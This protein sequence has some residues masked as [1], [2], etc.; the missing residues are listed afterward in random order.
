MLWNGE[1]DHRFNSNCHWNEQRI[2]TL[3][4]SFDVTKNKLLNERVV[5]N[6][7]P[8]RELAH[9][10]Q[11]VT[12]IP[13]HPINSFHLRLIRGETRWLLVESVFT[14]WWKKTQQFVGNSIGNSVFNKS[15]HTRT[16]AIL[17]SHAA[18]L[19]AATSSDLVDEHCRSPSA[20]VSVG[21]ILWWFSWEVAQC[22]AHER[23][24]THTGQHK[25]Q[26]SDVTGTFI[27]SPCAQF[28]LQNVMLS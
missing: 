19:A 15:C 4:V 12:N 18:P 6:R 5:H 7:V 13:T 10:A 16:K 21:G 28:Q 9:R 20:A 25:Y 1:R 24:T 11:T 14:T 8:G 26:V 27:T 3:C 2:I 22:H 23:H 17:F